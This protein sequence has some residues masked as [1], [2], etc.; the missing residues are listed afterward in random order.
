MSWTFTTAPGWAGSVAS[1]PTGD[2][3]ADWFDVAVPQLAATGQGQTPI[4]CVVVAR[5]QTPRLVGAKGLAKRLMDALHDQ[6]GTGA[7]HGHV[8]PLGDDHPGAVRG[9]AVEVR[10]GSEPRTEYTLGSELLVDASQLC[11]VE[12][13]VDCPNDVGAS[14]AEN[15]RLRVARS[16]FAEATRLAWGDLALEPDSATAILIRHARGRDEDNT[17]EGWLRAIKPLI[18]QE[19]RAI[20]SLADPNLSCGV[21]FEI[22][23]ASDRAVPAPSHITNAPQAPEPVTAMTD[24]RLTPIKTEEEFTQAVES[25]AFIVIRDK[26]TKSLR[27]HHATCASVSLGSFR[28]KVVEGGGKTGEYHRA[29]SLQAATDAGATPC[30]RCIG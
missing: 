7:K 22:F 18:G 13:D 23:S 16:A 21:V 24:I 26:P 11:R 12:V 28:T 30:G 20:A 25:G 9:L 15:Q 3:A 4:P 17:W 1:A 8:A 2:R 29:S 10:A 5:V 14:S 6:R 19:P 27:V